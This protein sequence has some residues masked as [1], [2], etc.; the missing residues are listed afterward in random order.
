M[1]NK[2]VKTT[3]A[4]AKTAGAATAPATK[5]RRKPGQIDLPEGLTREALEAM[6]AQLKTPGDVHQ[7]LAQLNRAV[8]ERMLQEEMQQHL[9]G[10]AHGDKAEPEQTNRRNG[11]TSKTLR[12]ELGHTTIQ[13]PRDREGSFEPII[14]EK[15]QRDIGPMEAKILSLYSKSMSCKDIQETLQELYGIEVSTEFISSVTDAVVEEVRRFQ[16]RLVPSARTDRSK[17][18]TPWSTLMPSTCP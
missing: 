15:H 9:G 10:R 1:E 2:N 11:T 5:T 14:V 8:L 6:T 12:G 7:L 17:P 13:V 4:V 18:S 16:R 3:T